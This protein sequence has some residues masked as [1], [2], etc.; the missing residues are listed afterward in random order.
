MMHVVQLI[1]R[2][3]AKCATQWDV[4]Q[5]YVTKHPSGFEPMHLYLMQLIQKFWPGFEPHRAQM[6]KSAKPV[7]GSN[8][9]ELSQPTN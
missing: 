5:K 3:G 2:R 7:R 8:V 1:M 4:M 6:Q 9:Y